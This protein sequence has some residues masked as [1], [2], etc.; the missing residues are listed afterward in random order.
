MT[1]VDSSRTTME[2]YLQ[3]LLTRGGF[4]DYLSDDVAL[5]IVGSGQS[6]HGRTEVAGM[7]RHI[8]EQAFDATA[9]LKSLVV[10]GHR[11]AIE[12]DFV[13]RHTAEFAG[14]A[15]TDRRVCV[16]YSVHYDLRTGG[17]VSALRI[18][19][20]ADGLVHALTA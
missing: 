12:A 7:I 5:E 13:G 18:Y 17:Q 9:K 16:P 20:L 19:G 8:H 11:A 3:A 2:S 14:I 1:V 4:A 6:A 15:A 10:E